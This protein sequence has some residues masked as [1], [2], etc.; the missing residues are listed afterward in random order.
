MN[1]YDVWI[2]I[3]NTYHRIICNS[4]LKTIT[5]KLQKKYDCIEENLFEKLYFSWQL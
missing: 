3:N 2:D 1:K 4:N 5:N